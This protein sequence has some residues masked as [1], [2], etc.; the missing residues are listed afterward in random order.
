[1]AVVEAEEEEKEV[2]KEKQHLEHSRGPL[3]SNC[4]S[5]NHSKQAHAHMIVYGFIPNIYVS[6]CLMKMYVGCSSLTYAYIVF[7]KMSQ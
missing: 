2:K 6:N 3:Y 7:D 4:N 1:M 5:L